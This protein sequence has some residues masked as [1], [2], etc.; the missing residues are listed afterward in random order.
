MTKL[1]DWVTMSNYKAYGEDLDRVFFTNN[2]LLDYLITGSLW[3]VGSSSFCI[4]NDFT[5]RSSPVRAIGNNQ[6]WVQIY[7]RSGGGSG[8]K[9]DGTLW[10]WGSNFSGQVGDGTTNDA[11][12]PVTTAGGGNDWAYV[13]AGDYHIVAI[14][15]N[16]TA[17]SFGQNFAG[18]LGVGTLDAGRS[19]PTSVLGGITNWVTSAAGRNHS[20][21]IRATGQLY[22]WGGNG[23]GGVGDASGFAQPSPVTTAG[24][25]TNWKFVAF[26]WE[27][28]MAVKTDGTLWCWGQNDKGQVGD[29]T[30]TDRSS[31]VTV[32]GGGTTWKN[33]SGG[34][35]FTIATKTDGTLWTWG[36]NPYGE[37]GD[38]TITSRSSPNTVA[39]GGTTWKQT[40]CGYYHV[41]AIKT[42]GTLWTWGRNNRGQ[43][44]TNNTTN[45]SSPG[46][47]LSNVTWKQVG[48]GSYGTNGTA[49]F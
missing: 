27:H 7:C 2:E 16:G 11:L 18:Q 23:R 36:S 40:A 20:G 42:D 13:G 5:S 33:A 14:K 35:R 10:S 19:S 22:V 43:L 4:Q 9:T 6:D 37:L 8:I 38:G 25:G 21:A 26:G 49:E 28:T 29:G 1:R 15:T 41:T 45:R 34:Y 31:P 24:G 48:A 44:G 39:G 46:S 32:A 30:T 17:W 12:S 3:G 47:I